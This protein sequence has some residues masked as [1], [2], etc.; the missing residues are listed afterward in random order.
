MD[1]VEFGTSDRLLDLENRGAPQVE[2]VL[3]PSTI[4]Q[5]MSNQQKKYKVPKDRFLIGVDSQ[6]FKVWSGILVVALVYTATVMPYTV[7]FLDSEI[8]SWVFF[9]DLVL[10]VIFIIDITINFNVPY[11]KSSLK[12]E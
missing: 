11:Q 2:L 4:M 8:P 9:V 7:A 10:E 6:F 5:K 1:V 12:Y 3:K